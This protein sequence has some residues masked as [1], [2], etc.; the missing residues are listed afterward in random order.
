M[1]TLFMAIFISSGLAT[2]PVMAQKV[3][4]ARLQ[5]TID[6]LYTVEAKLYQQMA[7]ARS[8]SALL[9]A[10]RAHSRTTERHQHKLQTLISQYGFPTYRW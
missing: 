8:D 1:R 4:Q 2:T 6:S 7:A 3:G 9:V 10:E 5:V